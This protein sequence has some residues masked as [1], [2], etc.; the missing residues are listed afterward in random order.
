V[1]VTTHNKENRKARVLAGI[2]LF[3]QEQGYPPSYRDLG[4]YVGISHSLIHGYVK[5]LRADGLIHERDP[6]I[7]RSLTL[8]DA[9]RRQLDAGKRGQ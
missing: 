8:T 7:S 6:K 9:G 1:T 5:E 2:A 4:D 3:Q